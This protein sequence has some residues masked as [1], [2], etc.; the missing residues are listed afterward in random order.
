MTSTLQQEGGNKLRITASEVMRLAQSLYEGGFITYMRT[1][2]VILADDAL[3]AVRGEIVSSFGN[4]FLSAEPRA[5]KSKVKNAQEA[6][7]A[8]R[9]TL[10]L[11]SPDVVGSELNARELALYKLIW[12]RTLASQMSDATGTT[13][14]VKLGAKTSSTTKTDCEFSTSGTTITFPG[15]R[16]AYQEVEEDTESEEKEALL[17]AMKVGDQ[18]KIEKFVA[19]GHVTSPPARYTEPTLVKKLEE[20]GI[21]R[22]STYAAI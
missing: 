15:Y 13:V 4:D 9:P 19:S 8:I 3:A 5:Y 11:R 14:T 1:D 12:Q 21:G 17:P 22:P 16:Q 2:N 6:H 18:V 10:P 7:E 20:L